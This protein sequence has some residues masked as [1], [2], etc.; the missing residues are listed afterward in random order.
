LRLNFVT[1]LEKYT[2]TVTTKV[3]YMH[4][5]YANNLKTIH[6]HEMANT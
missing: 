2:L 4:K 3:V 6:L 5:P 1:T